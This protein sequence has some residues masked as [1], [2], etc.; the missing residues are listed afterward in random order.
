M[1][2]TGGTAEPPSRRNAHI[3]W[4]FSTSLTASEMSELGE[5]S[6]SLDP[7]HLRLVTV[8]RQEA[9]KGTD[10]LIEALSLLAEDYPGV[11]LDIIGDGS[12]IPRLK[13]LAAE[14]RVRGQVTFRGKLDHDGVLRLMQEAHIF[15]FPS[16]SEGFPKA[17]LE[18]MACGL[19]VIATRVSVLPMLLSSGGGMLIDPNAASIAAA[20]HR[21]ASCRKT[22]DTMSREARA[23]AQQYTLES[24]GDTIGG[25][26]RGAWGRLKEY[27]ED[28]NLKP[29]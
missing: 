11:Q 12:D 27:D 20:V 10:K 24:W 15:C 21:V 4:V 28:G 16:L 14:L 7:T 13:R 8:G 9:K 5:H 22:Y 3:R 19:P 18:A 26:L 29:D 17:V 1:L 2:A 6:P 23:V 25:H